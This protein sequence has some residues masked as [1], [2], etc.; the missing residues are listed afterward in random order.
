MEDGRRRRTPWWAGH[1]LTEEKQGGERQE[2]VNH[3]RL[4]QVC[5]VR[6]RS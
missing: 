4:V 1:S 6:A 2:L 5:W 3:L